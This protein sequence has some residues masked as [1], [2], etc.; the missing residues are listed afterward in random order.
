MDLQ[1]A[2]WLDTSPD[3][4]LNSKSGFQ[5]K[6]VHHLQWYSHGQVKCLGLQ[7]YSFKVKTSVLTEI[8][9]PGQATSEPLL[10]FNEAFTNALM[11]T[12]SKPSSCP[13]VKRQV[14]IHRRSVLGKPYFLTDRLFVQASTSKVCPNSFPM[15]PLGRESKRTVIWVVN[16]PLQHA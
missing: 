5:W 4:G 15:I 1:E 16:V 10:P 14:A 3:T 9:Q 13:P 6:R 8:L 12:W 11:G 7:L 2:R